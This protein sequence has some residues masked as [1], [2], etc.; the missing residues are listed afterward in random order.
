MTSNK[1]YLKTKLDNFKTFVKTTFPTNEII[2]QQL[3][4]YNSMPIESFILYVKQFILPM[5]GSMDIFMKKLALDYKLNINEID[6]KDKD[7][8]KRY[9]DLFVEVVDEIVNN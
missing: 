9:F 2:N 5:K 4:Q 6:S 3:E 7:K 1:E 8:F